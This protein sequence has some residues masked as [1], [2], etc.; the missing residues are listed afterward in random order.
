MDPCGEDR[1]CFSDWR[2]NIHGDLITKEHK[3]QEHRLSEGQEINRQRKERKDKR[4]M[5]E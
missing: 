3:R 2:D 1:A 5:N 4:V